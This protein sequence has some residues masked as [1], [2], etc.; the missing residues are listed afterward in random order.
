MSQ[1]QIS[2]ATGVYVVKSLSE[3]KGVELKSGEFLARKIEKGTGKESKGVVIPSA[4]GEQFLLALENESILR[5][6]INW[7][8]SQVEECCKKRIE[9]G[10]TSLV[11]NDF[12]TSAVAA[13]LDEKEITESRVSKETIG[14]WFS[15]TVQPILYRA[16]H[17]KLGESLTN[18]KANEL[19]KMY[20]DAFKCF[21]KREYSFSDNA[22]SNMEKALKMIP[23]SNMKSFCEKKLIEMSPKK[24]DDWGL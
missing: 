2:A 15:A 12:S 19:L 13:M 7:F 8:Q 14:A 1:N 24:V 5:G 18:D 11:V 23:E 17:E 22:Y 20:Q 6:A 10:A 9:E 3:F 16:F 4:T 21:A